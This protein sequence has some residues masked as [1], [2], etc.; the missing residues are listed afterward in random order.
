MRVVCISDTHGAYGRL[1][2]PDG[3]ILVHA[4]DITAHG[5]PIEFKDFNDWLG[6]LPHTHK[7]V[8]AGNH[9]AALAQ[10][11]MDFAKSV[12]S[13]AHYLQD[14]MVVVDDVRIYGAPWTPEFNGWHFMLPRGSAAF[15]KKWSKI[16]EGLDILLTHGPPAGKCD[17]SKHQQFYVGCDY[18]REA[19]LKTRPRFHVFGHVHESYGVQM[20]EH[21]TFINA[22]IMT[23]AYIPTNS[24]IEIE[25]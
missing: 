2:V 4:G 9:D 6:G 12:L 3:D 11:S 25:V 13:N 10:Q 21:T 7:V 14:S 22:S 5:R 17:Y 20:G 18:L 15:R 19:V 23:R 1:D 8:I 24:P 16:P